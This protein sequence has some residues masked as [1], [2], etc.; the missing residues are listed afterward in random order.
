MRLISVLLLF[1]T[2]TLAVGAQL[3][4]DITQA[5]FTFGGLTDQ[6]SD[7]IK[8]DEQGRAIFLL[9]VNGED[10]DDFSA[11]KLTLDSP[12]QGK[13]AVLFWETQQT[14]AEV[15]RAELGLAQKQDIEISLANHPHWRGNLTVL[16]IGL[17]GAPGYTVGIKTLALQSENWLAP[18]TNRLQSWLERTPWSMRSI[19]YY[20]GVNNDNVWL[21]PTPVAA[22]LWAL[23][24][25]A[26]F[27]FTRL[28]GRKQVSLILILS[29]GVWVALDALWLRQLGSRA[30]S[31]Q[32]KFQG[33]NNEQALS[34][35]W[36]GE[37]H[38]FSRQIT[39]SIHDQKARIFLLTKAEYSALRTAY[40]LTPLNTYW[41]RSNQ[42]V[43]SVEHI[44]EGDYLVIIPPTVIAYD[45]A[46]RELIWPDKSRLAVKPMLSVPGSGFLF[47]ALKDD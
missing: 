20:S 6:S 12:F 2:S 5:E 46:R 45:E 38:K 32:D 25:V 42:A 19:N 11:L 29:L 33:M 9:P 26:A 8:F 14:G 28:R 44:H 39:E 15:S 34:A 41:A 31:T 24:V 4:W 40:F 22:G 7:T 43:P 23:V 21:S 10:L 18:A 36:D 35:N 30:L 47:Q 27:I 17:T 16:G 13:V 3:S 1:S 37:L